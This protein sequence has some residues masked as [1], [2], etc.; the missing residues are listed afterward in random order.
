LGRAPARFDDTQLRY[1]QKEAVIA[2]SSAELAEWFS[3]STQGQQLSADWGMERVQGLIDVVRDNVELPSD[4]AGW[5]D[6]LSADSL[7]IDEPERTVVQSAGETFFNA[8]LHQ[9]DA[10]PDSFKSF[11]KAVGK[12]AGVKGK[13]LFMPLRIALTGVT[14]GPEMARVWDWLGEDRCRTRLQAAL[15]LCVDGAQSHAETV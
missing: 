12:A 5:A 14:H 15:K 8:A 9:L 1:W 7:S 4:V 13:Q 3:Q 11:A 10:G 2:A 6:R